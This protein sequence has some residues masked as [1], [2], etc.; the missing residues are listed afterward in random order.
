M[1]ARYESLYHGLRS[2]RLPSA[3]TSMRSTSRLVRWMLQR[4]H[5]T[6]IVEL[7]MPLDPLL[8]ARWNKS[9]SVIVATLLRRRG[10]V[11]R[12]AID[13]TTTTMMMSIMMR[14]MMDRMALVRRD[15]APRYAKSLD[16]LITRFDASSTMSR[17]ISYVVGVW[18]RMVVLHTSG[19]DMFVPSLSFN[20]SAGECLAALSPWRSDGNHPCQRRSGCISR[21][22]MATARVCGAQPTTLVQACIDDLPSLTRPLRLIL[23]MHNDS[24]GAWRVQLDTQ[25]AT[26]R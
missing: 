15:R 17:F 12:E 11:D 2:T 5:S 21:C 16:G 13:T 6:L 4:L 8:R 9:R 25:G 20:R 23:L 7:P 19:S 22:T 24:I 1:W 18:R 26:G 10:V 14:T 3:C